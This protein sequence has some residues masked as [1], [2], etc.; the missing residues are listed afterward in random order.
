MHI[1]PANPCTFAEPARARFP[2]RW[3]DPHP[4]LADPVVIHMWRR[5]AGNLSLPTA[6]RPVLPNESALLRSVIDC[7]VYGGI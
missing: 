5:A 6:R 1:P 2:F 4:T 3:A 7:V